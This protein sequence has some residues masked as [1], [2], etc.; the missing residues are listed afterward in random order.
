MNKFAV[1]CR[2][3]SSITSSWGRGSKV[4]DVQEGGG[5]RLFHKILSQ[6][7]AGVK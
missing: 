2:A 7:N 6:Q 1:L 5:F 4:W 3:L